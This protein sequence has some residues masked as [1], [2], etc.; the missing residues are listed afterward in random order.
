MSATTSVFVDEYLIEANGHV[1]AFH[2]DEQR[3]SF[4][5]CSCGWSNDTHGAERMLDLWRKHYDPS[6]ALP[7]ESSNEG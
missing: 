7:E 1:G 4:C 5:Y 2:S 6:P 3:V